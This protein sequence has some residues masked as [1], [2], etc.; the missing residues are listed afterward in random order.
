MAITIVKVY[1][2]PS[3]SDRECKWA[4]NSLPTVI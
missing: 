3:H 2:E 1:D 4:T